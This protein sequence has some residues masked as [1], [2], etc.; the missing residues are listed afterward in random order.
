VAERTVPL[1]GTLAALRARK[2]PDWIELTAASEFV[3]T[4]AGLAALSL[5]TVA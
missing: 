3:D 4:R 2:T 5:E 1:P